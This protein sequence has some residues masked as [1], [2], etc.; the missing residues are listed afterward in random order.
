M[1]GLA[2]V[3]VAPEDLA[4]LRAVAADPAAEFKVDL[5]AR[6]VTAGSFSVPLA[7]PD[8]TREAL[9]SGSWDATGILLD[10]YADVEATAS[11]LPYIRGF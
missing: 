8:A 4:R 5:A 10:G 1:I 3:Q 9:L 7:M 6:R 11:R 2:C